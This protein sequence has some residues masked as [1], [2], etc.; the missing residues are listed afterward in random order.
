[1]ALRF[2][3]P[4]AAEDELAR[5]PC[6]S[7]EPPLEQGVGESPECALWRSSLTFQYVGLSLP[8]I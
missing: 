6:E 4:T 1:M 2:L 5:P 8:E 3:R 7:R